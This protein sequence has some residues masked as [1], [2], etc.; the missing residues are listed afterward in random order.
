[1]LPPFRQNRKDKLLQWLNNGQQKVM[2]LT[3]GLLYN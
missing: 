1:M 2:G 3:S